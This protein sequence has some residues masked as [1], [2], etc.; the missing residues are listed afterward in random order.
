MG[1]TDLTYEEGQTPLEPD[2]KE[3][4]LIPS[5]AT[6]GELNEVEQRNIEEAIRWT[7][8]RRR[9]FTAEEILSHEFVRELHRRM[10]GNVWK[11]AGAFR[12]SNKNIGVD[13][14]S[15]STEL[16][17]LLDDSNYWLDH[18]TFG[19]DETA[20]RFKHRIVSIHCFAN[21]NDKTTS[22]NENRDL[23]YSTSIGALHLNVPHSSTSIPC[24][25]SMGRMDIVNSSTGAGTTSLVIL[26]E[27]RSRE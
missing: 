6:R 20:V 1:L 7:I 12:L 16:R 17:M 14:H 8:D 11:W 19:Q 24:R 13:K 5:I 9:K 25:L 15:I 2:E 27:P 10:F 3:G 21:G 22:D 18:K 4:L 23:L 26:V